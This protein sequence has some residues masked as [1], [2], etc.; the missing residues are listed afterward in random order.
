[1]CDVALDPYTSHGHDGILKSN[2]VL[3]DETIKILINQS[4]LQAEMGCDVHCTIRYDG[5]KNW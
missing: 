3:N 5:W 2:Y 1:M 4:L